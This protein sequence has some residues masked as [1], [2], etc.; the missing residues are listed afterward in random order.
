MKLLSKRETPIENITLMGLGASINVAL[1]LLSTFIPF[2]SFFVILFLPLVSALVAFYCKDK[3]LILYIVSSAGVSLLSTCYD[4]SITL[5][6]VIPALMIGTLFGF[7]LKKNFPSDYLIFFASLVKVGLNYLMLLLLKLIYG[8]DI[9]DSL[10]KVLGLQEVAG[11]N[12]IIP[13]FIFG[14]SLIQELICYLII[15]LSSSSL[16]EDGGLFKIRIPFLNAILSFVFIGIGFGVSFANISIGYFLSALGVYFSI[17]SSLDIFRKN[18]WWLYL[19]LGILCAASFYLSAF[20]Y[21]KLDK[22]VAPLL[23]LSFF[24]SISLCGGVSSL[25]FKAKKGEKE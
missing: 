17:S 16:V 10:L 24:A 8:V 15:S 4:I 12:Q 1:A 5:F 23:F 19:L 2:S 3:Y 11:I 7:L 22:S 14:Y 9:I 21:D 25:L 18:P 20:L 13:T 6:D